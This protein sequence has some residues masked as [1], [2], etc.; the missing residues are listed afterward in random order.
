MIHCSLYKKEPPRNR[1][2]SALKQ[3]RNWKGWR[4]FKSLTIHPFKSIFSKMN[5]NFRF[6]SQGHRNGL[7]SLYK[8]MESCREYADIQVMWKMIESSS[9]QI[10]CKKK[11]IIKS[12]YWMICFRP[13]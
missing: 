9:P 7:V 3:M 13:T 8:D 10:A 12:S 4:C 2:I 5:S 11:K 6:K 1:K